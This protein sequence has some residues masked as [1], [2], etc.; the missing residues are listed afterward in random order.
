M[1]L[2][3]DCVEEIEAVV[4]TVTEEVDVVVVV[5]LGGGLFVVDVPGEDVSEDDVG[6]W[7]VEA[8]DV[9]VELVV[10]DDGAMLVVEV[11]LVDDNSGV[12]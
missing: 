3:K 1:I 10:V 4:I 9:V 12:E 7:L 8:A 2:V 11:S 6:D 5:V